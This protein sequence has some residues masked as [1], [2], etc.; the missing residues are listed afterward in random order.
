MNIHMATE[1]AYKNGYDKAV[2]NLKESTVW[3]KISDKKYQCAKCKAI[4]NR[5]S[6][7]CPDCGRVVDC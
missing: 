6:K 7:F 5:P 4:N 1:V 2:K 3:E